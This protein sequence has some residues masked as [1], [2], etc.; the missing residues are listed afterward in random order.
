MA[1]AKARA[2]ATAKAKA[3]TRAKWRALQSARSST[4]KKCLTPPALSERRCFNSQHIKVLAF[5]M[6]QWDNEAMKQADGARHPGPMRVMHVDAEFAGIIVAVGFLVMGA[7][8]LDIGKWFVLG[9]LALGAVVAL[10][11]RFTR[12][13]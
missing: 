5:T 9:A 1:K 4:L 2:R 12:K 6:N 10:L 3:S 13:E 8:G 11:L 7:V